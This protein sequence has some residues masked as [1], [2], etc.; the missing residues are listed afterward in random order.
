MHSADPPVMVLPDLTAVKYRVVALER[1]C[2]VEFRV[3][4]SRAALSEEQ[5]GRLDRACETARLHLAA[6]RDA[7][8]LELGMQGI[9]AWCNDLRHAEGQ[10]CPT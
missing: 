4:I 3:P 5:A 10:R 1:A 7:V 6:E 9:C 2:L 8:A